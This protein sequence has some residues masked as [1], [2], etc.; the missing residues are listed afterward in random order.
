M[1]GGGGGISGIKRWHFKIES[2][3]ISISIS[4]V[5]CIKYPLKNGQ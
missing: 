4:I 3:Y 5:H 2:R 1:G